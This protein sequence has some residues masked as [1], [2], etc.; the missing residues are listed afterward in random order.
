MD[1]K[2]KIL[3]GSGCA[4]GVL[5]IAYGIGVYFF[6]THFLCNS[7]V[8]GISVSTLTASSAENALTALDTEVITI[9]ERNDETETIS[10]SDI[11]YSVSM[12]DGVVEDLLDS[13]NAF[14]WPLSLFQTREYDAAVNVSYDED[15]LIS[16]VE[17]LEAMNEENMILPT[18]ATIA[19]NEE[20]V[21]EIVAEEVGTQLTADTVKTTVQE[22]V[23]N[24]E[25]TINLEENGCYTSPSVTS[26]DETLTESLAI[27]Q[28]LNNEVISLDMRGGVVITMEPLELASLFTLSEDG[29]AVLN[30]T[31]LSEY[32]DALAE[33]YNTYETERTF[34]T[35]LGTEITVGGSGKDTYGYWMNEES[36]LSSIQTAITSGTTQT[37]TTYWDL[38]ANTRTA[39]NGD[40]GDTYIEISISEQKLWFYLDGELYLEADVITGLP[41]HNQDTPTGVFRIWAKETDRTLE[42]TA[43]DGSTWSSFVNYWMPITWTGVGLHDASWQSAFGGSLYLTKGSHGCINLA[44]ATAYTLYTTAPLDTPV[45]IYS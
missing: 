3:I 18:D 39:E 19:L 21:Y 2:K 16:Q 9:E 1:T 26:E 37:V 28:A 38:S 17:S 42:G 29:S 4:A 40:I 10:L 30:E 23:E 33:E 27:L 41:E 45:I 6:S 8:N 15:A 31:A 32:V 13:Q 24:G 44:Y 22:A 36:T 14:A 5:V 11:S 25:L 34:T 35:S 43:Y 20:S 7:Y 12:D